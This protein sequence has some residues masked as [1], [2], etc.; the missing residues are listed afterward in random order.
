MT[1]GTQ[2]QIDAI[3]KRIDGIVT[4]NSLADPSP[5][6]PG[7][8]SKTAPRP[9]VT[10]PEPEK[11][12]ILWLE[13]GDVLQDL[14][15]LRVITDEGLGKHIQIG[16][17]IN[18]NKQGR[19]NF[20][21]QIDLDRLDIGS[22][23]ERYV[24]NNALLKGTPPNYVYW[25]YE[26]KFV[27]INNGEVVDNWITRRQYDD[28]DVALSERAAADLRKVIRPGE[29]IA[30]YG[31]MPARAWGPKGVDYDQRDALV[32]M[33]APWDWSYLVLYQREAVTKDNKY[34]HRDRIYDWHDFYNDASGGKPV[35]PVITPNLEPIDDLSAKVY[36]E[37]IMGLSSK[38]G[39]WVNT[40]QADKSEAG[41]RALAPY[42]RE[43]VG[44]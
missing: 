1:T 5:G 16:A 2:D 31:P 28:H 18:S 37:T 41:I 10:E 11:P 30:L 8:I 19:H 25:D 43:A 44:A 42:L 36:V 35:I 20:P 4:A 26:P 13:G 7:P 33:L 34:R 23:Y 24:T 6:K 39:I 14:H 22:H 29:K 32:R 9:V 38:I 15:I 40:T 17:Q 27:N 21:D 3:S 12:I